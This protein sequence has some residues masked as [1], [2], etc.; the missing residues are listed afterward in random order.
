MYVLREK[1][2]YV[3]ISIDIHLKKKRLAAQND[4]THYTC[5]KKKNIQKKKTH[6]E[7]QDNRIEFSVDSHL[8]S[9][10]FIYIYRY[11]KYI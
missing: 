1:K 11:T 7:A 10:Y 6:L 4:Y 3:K 8:K 5:I 9:K 2:V